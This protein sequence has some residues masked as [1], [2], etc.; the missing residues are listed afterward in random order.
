MWSRPDVAIGGV[1]LRGTP[2][3]GM[4]DMFSRGVC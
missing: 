2:I 4:L 1:N 3:L